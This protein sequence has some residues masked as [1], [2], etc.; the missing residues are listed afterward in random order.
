MIDLE[1]GKAFECDNFLDA[2]S[3]DAIKSSWSVQSDA[4][5]TEI[6]LRSLL[7]PGYVGY[8][9]TNSVIFGGV[10]MGNGLRS[11]DLPFIV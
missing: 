3:S 11:Q 9:R 10:Y 2:L 7:W 8:H 4:S 5:R 1:S 6:T